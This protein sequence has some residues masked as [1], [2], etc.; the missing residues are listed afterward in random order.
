MKARVFISCGQNKSSD[1]ATVALSI[2]NWLD[3]KGYEA[4]VA[5]DVISVR[6]LRE[7]IFDQLKKS[8]YFLFVDFKRE[9]VIPLNCSKG[10]T[11]RGSLFTHQE[12]ALASYL[13]LP[14]LA[15]RHESVR[16]TEGMLGVMQINSKPF[17]D[18]SDVLPLVEV[19]VD[20]AEKRG[21]WNNKHK[22]TLLFGDPEPSRIVDQGTP[23][24]RKTPGV[25]APALY[26]WIP[27]QNGS[28]LR[29]AQNCMIGVY[30]TDPTQQ[31]TNLEPTAPPGGTTYSNIRGLKWVGGIERSESF[32][33]A[34]KTPI[35]IDIASEAKFTAVM[36]MEDEADLG[37]LATIGDAGGYFT[38][39]FK[40]P[41]TFDLTY[42]IISTNFEPVFANYRLTLGDK[43]EPNKFKLERLP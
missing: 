14:I 10:K 25:S 36:I 27:I 2:K 19:E 21:E 3:S 11:Y 22:N 33:R 29:E 41:G 1:E 38:P 42:F 40:G 24:W 17:K 37:H 7:N 12:L 9:R 26:Y 20:A 32:A 23:T 6:G 15:F 18:Y 31:L 13:E 39:F 8:D 4:Y 16:A 30:Y 28:Y 35:G 5:I 43:H 34:I